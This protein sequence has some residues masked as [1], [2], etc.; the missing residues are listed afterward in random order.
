MYYRVVFSRE[1]YLT[2]GTRLFGDDQDSEYGRLEPV[3]LME[4]QWF[5]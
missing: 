3:G 1:I 2:V 4:I 5:F